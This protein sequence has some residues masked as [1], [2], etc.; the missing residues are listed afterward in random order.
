MLGNGKISSRQ[1]GVLVFLYTVGTTILVV[2]AGLASTAKQ[3]AWIGALVGVCFGWL[4][5]WSYATLWRLYP[6]KTFVG[7]CEAALGKFFGKI[8]SLVFVFYSFIGASTVLFYLGNFFKIQF[9]PQTPIVF[10]N[11]LFAIIIVMGIRLGIEV[12]SRT[13]ELLMPWFIILFCVLVFTLTPEIKT[14]NLQPIFESGVKPLIGA[15]LSFAGT[16][17]FPLIFLFAI[18]PN[19][20]NPEQARKIFYRAALIGGLCVVLVTLLCILILGTNITSRSMFPSFT[21]VRKI[22]LGNFLQRI[23]AIMAGLWFITTYYKTTLYFFSGVSS[24]G[25]ILK[26]KDYRPLALPLGMILVLYSLIV[27]P[28]IVY[29][30]KWDSTIFIPYI[31]TIGLLI[32]LLLVAAGLLKKAGNGN[33]KTNRNS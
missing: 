6:N 22:N 26:L 32:P 9:I 15:G 21:L 1:L 19:V 18:I 8:L 10:I 17:Y 7:I 2:P 11:A 29:M 16:A 27:Y 20:L 31:L 25:E 23:E 24:L 30:Q 14:E 12:I 3:D 33:R 28:D 5:L 13:A 4:I